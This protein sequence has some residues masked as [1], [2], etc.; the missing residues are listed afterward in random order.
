MFNK[1]V[2]THVCGQSVEN[3]RVPEGVPHLGWQQTLVLKAEEKL[4]KPGSLQKRG[5]L[6][7]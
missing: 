6:L 3:H 5:D 2:Y 4:Q 1:A 7:W